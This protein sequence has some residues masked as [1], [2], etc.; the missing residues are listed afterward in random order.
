MGVENFGNIDING[1]QVISD[2]VAAFMGAGG[3]SV[4][5]V[6]SADFTIN[7]AFD[8]ATDQN[9]L[10]GTDS[11]VPGGVGEILMTVNVEPGGFPGPYVCS[12]MLTGISAADTPVSDTSNDG[13]DP[14][15]DGDGD[16]VE[17]DPTVVH[18]PLP[19]I[20][21]PTLDSVGLIAMA[22]FLVGLAAARLRHRRLATAAYP[23]QP[24]RPGRGAP[25]T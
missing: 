4:G 2:L 13:D 24:L 6:T 5:S 23:A 3:F 17:A 14:D 10:A 19:P 22:L 9:L 21:I 11:L 25:R 7:P 12:A 18:L 20:E 1:L 16:P 15:P 8:G